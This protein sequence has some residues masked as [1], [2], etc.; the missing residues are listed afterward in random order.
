LRVL[1]VE[2]AYRAISWTTGIL[3]AMMP[4]AAAM[5]ESGAAEPMARALVQIVGAA[6]PY[7][8]LVGLFLLTAVLGQLVSNMATALVVSPIAMSAATGMEVSARPVLMTVT[9][10]AASFLTPVATRS[11]SW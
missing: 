5:Y 3:V 11:T 8:L 10:A 1:T 2:Q 4:L 6:G 7:A 9:V